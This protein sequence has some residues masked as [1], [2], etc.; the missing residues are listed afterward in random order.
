DVGTKLSVR[1]N[2]SVDGTVQLHVT[3]E[4][5]NATS[6]TQFNAPVISTRSI[7]TDLLVKDGHTIVL[8]GLSD[9]QRDVESRGIPFLSRIPFI[10]GL[11]GRQSRST[12]ETE[13]FVFLT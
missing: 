8:G 13:L 3:Q 10:G 12:T 4:V 2:I 5:S 6:E 9:R 7:K 11:F 1:P